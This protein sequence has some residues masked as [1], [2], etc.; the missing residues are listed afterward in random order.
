MKRRPNTTPV[1]ADSSAAAIAVAAL[2]PPAERYVLLPQIL[3]AKSLDSVAQTDPHVSVVSQRRREVEGSDELCRLTV[4]GY[5]ALAITISYHARLNQMHISK[6]GVSLLDR[7]DDM[8]E[9]RNRVFHAHAYRTV[10]S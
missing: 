7:R 4:V 6:V 1:F 10:K 8:G 5:N 9:L 3:R 2:C